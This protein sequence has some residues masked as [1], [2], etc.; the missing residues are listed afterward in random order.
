M[1]PEPIENKNNKTETKETMTPALADLELR[2]A[3]TLA[4]MLLTVAIFSLTLVSQR[5]DPNATTILDELFSLLSAV[6]L[7]GS[8]TIAD[9]AMDKHTPLG[10]RRRFKFF[11]GGYFLFCLTVG[12]MSA[13]IP[14]LYAST[15]PIAQWRYILFFFTGFS[16]I[17]KLMLGVETRGTALMFAC[18]LATIC[19]SAIRVIPFLD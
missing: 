5:P 1:K 14:I 12:T 15:A 3:T 18:Y 4:P 10:I 7:L 8:A 16:A 11:G 6:C 9:S 19:V 17:I 2:L 13:A